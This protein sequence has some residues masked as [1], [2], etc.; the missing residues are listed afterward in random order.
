MTQLLVTRWLAINFVGYAHFFTC[1]SE[2]P[3]RHYCFRF[4]ILVFHRQTFK[5]IIE[6]VVC[7]LHNSK[8]FYLWRAWRVFLLETVY[9]LRE[10]FLI[11]TMHSLNVFWR[12]VNA[13]K[14]RIVQEATKIRLQT[15]GIVKFAHRSVVEKEIH[16]PQFKI[17]N[18]FIRWF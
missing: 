10:E 8:Q 17:I 3:L 6:S 12:S 13:L 5:C 2:K 14:N 7:R 9:K 4:R 16:F 1:L 11:T 18:S 15:T